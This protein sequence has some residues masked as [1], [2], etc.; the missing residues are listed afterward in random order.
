MS[1]QAITWALDYRARS[2]TEKVILLVLAN[3]ANEYG[4]S[5]PSQRT[6]ADQTALGER[7]VRR[8]LGAMEAKGIIRRI[9]RRRGNGSRQSDMI[10]LLA[11]EGRKPAPPGLLEDEEEPDY[12]SHSEQPANR[13]NRPD[14]PPDNRPQRPHPPVTVAALDPSLI[15]KDSAPSAPPNSHLACLAVAGPGLD[16]RE[17]GPL[18]LS[19]QEIDRWLRGGCDLIADILPVIA[20]K[21]AETRGQPIRSW[22]YFTA[23]IL[24]AKTRREAP[25]SQREENRNEQDR[26][27]RRPAQRGRA[28][29]RG[30]GDA[31][32]AAIAELDAEG[33]APGTA[34]AGG[35]RP[36]RPDGGGAE[37]RADA[38]DAEADRRVDRGTGLAL[39]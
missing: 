6:L 11:F 23:A 24:D 16:K 31:W 27:P 18:A 3:Y 1:V 15:L 30:F 22:A 19:A 26:R 12:P 38:G 17:R 29:S 4:I 7:T 35:T 37:G 20:A 32:D 10:L 13:D 34:L 36:D 21:T 25:L 9:Q 5:W 14:L 28:A 33:S 8:L 39:S 2:V